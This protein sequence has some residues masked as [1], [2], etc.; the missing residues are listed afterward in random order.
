MCKIVNQICSPFAHARLHINASAGGKT[1]HR[2]N[3]GWHTW[4]TDFGVVV[5]AH[6][7]HSRS[8]IAATCTS[9]TTEKQI[10]LQSLN[11]IDFPSKVASGSVVLFHINRYCSSCRS[12]ADIS[13]H[14]I[15]EYSP[16]SIIKLLCDECDVQTYIDDEI[17]AYFSSMAM[18]VEVD[19][20]VGCLLLEQHV[21]PTGRKNPAKFRNLSSSS[22]KW[23]Q[24]SACRLPDT[25]AHCARVENELK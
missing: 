14:R 18:K 25:C 10:I 15:I 17:I 11:D 2:S 13:A 4:W 12:H 5:V 3:A 6:F 24:N 7:L 21:R 23:I 20:V 8:C 9:V 1:L 19:D 22:I 16:P